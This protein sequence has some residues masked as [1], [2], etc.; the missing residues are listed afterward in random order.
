MPNF[1]FLPSQPKFFDLFEQASANLLDGARLLQNLLDDYTDVENKAAQITEVEHKGDDIVHEV[2]ALANVS[3]IAPIDHEDA[4]ELIFALDD[5]LDAVEA[6]ALRM[7]I[8]RVEQ[9]TETARQL[10][11][12]IQRGAAE[13]HVAM[14]GLRSRKQLVKMQGHIV[15]IHDL[16]NQGDQLL[17]RG[18]TDLVNQREDLF[19]LIRWKEIYEHLEG[20]T[21]R[22]EDVGDVLLR[23]LI[24]NA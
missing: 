3:L 19:N 7:A 15:A 13:L 2:T 11:A 5:A 24:K 8:Y 18:L 6:S 9:P 1:S 17:R 23:V 12:L 14:P 16:E 4:Q 22:I 20:A 10:A 21:D